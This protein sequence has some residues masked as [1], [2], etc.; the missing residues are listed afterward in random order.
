MTTKTSFFI[1]P[2][3]ND[4]HFVG[5]KNTVKSGPLGKARSP[6]LNLLWDY[7]VHG[8]VSPMGT[9]SSKHITAENWL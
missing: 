8:N 6:T 3:W 5:E 9:S 2:K 4:F 7:H 1:I